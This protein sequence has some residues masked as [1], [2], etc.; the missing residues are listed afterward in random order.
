MAQKKQDRK[1]T[2]SERA[3]ASSE[4]VFKGNIKRHFIR[5]KNDSSSKNRDRMS[6]SRKETGNYA[7]AYE[8]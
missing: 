7:F 2:E 4:E 3:S 8:H 5:P 1:I 6:Q